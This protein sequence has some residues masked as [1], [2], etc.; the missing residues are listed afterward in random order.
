[1]TKTSIRKKLR[2]TDLR[3]IAPGIGLDVVEID[4]FKLA[5]Q[6]RGFRGRVF[7]DKEIE[8]CEKKHDP[9][10]SYAARFAVKE[11]FY[12]ALND[13]TL[14][15]VPWKQVETVIEDQ[16][17]I[18]HFSTALRRRIGPRSVHLS[19]SHAEHVAVAVVLLL[20]ND[21]RLVDDITNCRSSQ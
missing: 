11:A 5:F 13:P 3:N 14:K 17:P 19:I 7:T 16:V 20:P 18:A 10:P 4:R 6:R 21:N 9:M 12:K 8:H 15:T 2:T 1:M